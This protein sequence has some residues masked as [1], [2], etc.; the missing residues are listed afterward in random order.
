MHGTMH[1]MYTVFLS[2]GCLPATVYFTPAKNCK[3]HES[4]RQSAVVGMATLHYSALAGA[5]Y[6]TL[7]PFVDHVTV[8]RTGIGNCKKNRAFPILSP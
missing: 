7:A 1:R 4:A 2:Y 6:K 5:R 8:K 3:S